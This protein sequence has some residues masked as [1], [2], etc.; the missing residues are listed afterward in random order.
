MESQLLQS[1]LEWVQA[2]PTWSY[3]I[4]FLIA[5]SESVFVLGLVVPGAFML[6]GVGALVPTGVIQIGPVLVS[7]ILGAVLGDCFSY[8]LG[9]H[10]RERLYRLWPMS[11]YPGVVVRGQDY[12][13]RHGGKSVLFGRFVGAVRPII[14]AVA[15]VAG[16]RPLQFF[17]VDVLSALAWAPCYIL[18]GAVVGASMGLVAE[19][20]SRLL[21]V[22]LVAGLLVWIV[23]WS[24][25]RVLTWLPAHAEGLVY[26][27]LDW[28]RR[29]RLLGRLG[30]GLADPTQPETPAL[31]MLA[32]LLLAVGWISLYLLW[33]IGAPRY[34]VPTDAIIYQLFQDLRSPG[35]DRIAMALAQL[36]DW[37]VYLP[38][39][40]TVL[41]TLVITDRR[42]AAWHWVAGLGFGALMAAGLG[43]LLAVPQPID[44]YRG[45]VDGRFAGGHSV[46]AA[47]VYGFLPVLLS[48]RLRVEK[49]WRYY[50]PFLS[51]VALIALANLYLGAQWLSDTLLGLGLGLTWVALLTLGYRRHRPQLVPTRSL[52]LF[53]VLA[54]VLG[55]S[56]Q[57]GSQ[58]DDDLRNYTHRI[59]LGT[60]PEVEW[61]AEAHARLPSYRVDLRGRLSDPLN[62]QW[63]GTLPDIKAKLIAHGWQATPSF[64]AS[65]TLLWLTRAPDIAQLPVM[66]QVHDGHY[67]ALTLR[68]PLDHDHQYV[69]RLWPSS[70]KLALDADGQLSPLWIGAIS[71]QHI[72]SLF[73][74]ASAPLTENDYDAPST[75]LQ[76][77]LGV[78]TSIIVRQAGHY[79]AN[80]KLVWDGSVLLLGA[81]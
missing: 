7:A 28:S 65:S 19:V 79:Q 60:M 81:H 76:T 33:G 77:Q 9:R 10:Y 25:R 24:T 52:V 46:F 48:S 57:W 4:V 2:N 47:V 72:Q 40:V 71:R 66:P 14:P 38:L 37:E 8:W 3:I 80:E 78:S 12:F 42:R 21:V 20:A 75:F 54:L 22:I 36:G 51:L 26:G 17:V 58:H 5:F 43:L 1:M 59:T 32:L 23:L 6:F 70:W 45:D 30:R 16:M 73:R 13:S 69:I 35:A 11:R 56:Y 29:H 68:H 34:P 55:A 67:A 53:A 63:A 62:L 31:A 74:L 39:S 50:V 44:Y 27:L 64:S 41:A 15:G 61:Q 49:R 18:P